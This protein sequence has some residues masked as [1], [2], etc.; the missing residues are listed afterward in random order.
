MT[1]RTEGDKR[2]EVGARV[3]KP[4][5]GAAIWLEEHDGP[6]GKLAAHRLRGEAAKAVAR[7]ERRLRE[8]A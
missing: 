3:V 8:R 5:I 4:L 2:A 6:Q 1:E 7:L